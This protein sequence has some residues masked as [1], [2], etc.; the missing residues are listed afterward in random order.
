[1]RTFQIGDRELQD[2]IGAALRKRLRKAGFAPGASMRGDDD[3]DCAFYFPINPNIGG[4]CTVTRDADGIWTI[5]QEHDTEIAER[6]G[7]SESIF[8]E[9]V[10]ANRVQ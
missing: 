1:M 7:A 8:I 3:L 4:K 2:L 6:L 10:R 9:A 5:S